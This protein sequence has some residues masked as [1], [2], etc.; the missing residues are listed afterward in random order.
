MG[1]TLEEATKAFAV[2]GKAYLRSANAESKVYKLGGRGN[3]FYLVTIEGG[4][5]VSFEKRFEDIPP[6]Q[7]EPRRCSAGCGCRAL[8]SRSCSCGI[9]C[10]TPRP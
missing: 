10:G 3:S 7:S 6:A 9:Y 2:D 4:K 1:M 8:G 5:V